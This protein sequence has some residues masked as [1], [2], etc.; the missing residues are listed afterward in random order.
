MHDH[1]RVWQKVDEKILFCQS[2]LTGLIFNNIFKKCSH[3]QIFLRQLGIDE[4][5]KPK[6]D[7]Q[8]HPT[9]ISN[10]S[11]WGLNLH[12]ITK[13]GGHTSTYAPLPWAEKQ[14]MGFFSW[15]HVF[16]RA[17][18]HGKHL[19]CCYGIQMFLRILLEK[20]K[21][22][23]TIIFI[24]PFTSPYHLLPID[25]SQLSSKAFRL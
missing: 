16:H 18:V 11:T 4:I 17:T 14:P 8:N 3:P 24:S 20:T 6:Q 2:S 1:D 21:K 7:Q 10:F 22:H 23:A 15:N 19:Q 12:L 9:Q 13:P 5:L 25:L